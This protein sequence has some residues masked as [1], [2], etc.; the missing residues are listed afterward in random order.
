MLYYALIRINK[1]ETSS[2]IKLIENKWKKVAPHTPFDF[3]FLD[4]TINSQYI[5]DRRWSK[6]INSA[7][8]MAIVI[9][10]LGLFGLTTIAVEKRVKEISIRKVLGASARN[11]TVLISREL[12]ILV[13]AA[14]ILAWPAAFYVLNRW[15]QGFAYRTNIEV[16]SFFISSVIAISIALITISFQS[17]K[18][19]LANPVNS[20]RNE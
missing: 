17:L 1:G 14:N 7:S 9:A 18:A 2:I 11:I 20:L 3:T 16:F 6:I 19:S 4:D 15:L 5:Q 13:A 10:C 12:L 8:V